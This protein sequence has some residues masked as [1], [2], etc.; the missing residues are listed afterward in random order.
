MTTDTIQSNSSIHGDSID[1]IIRP[2]VICGPSGSGK[3][4]LLRLLINDYKEYLGFTVSH[5]TRKPRE[6]EIDGREYHFTERESMEKA[7][8][9][10]EFI[11]F[12]EFSGNLYG[13]SKKAMEQVQKGGKICVLDLEIEGVKNMKKSNLKPLFVFV[14]PPSLEVLEQRLRARGTESIENIDRRLK[15]AKEDLCM[16]G[17][18]NYFDLIIINEDLDEAYAALKNF[19]Q[20]AIEIVKSARL[21]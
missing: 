9:D 16:E 5:T 18:E 20:P 8:K 17:I 11:E 4:T 10:G 14:K 21:N 1:P 12:T 19:I 2:I 7:I 13:T 15:R 3:S 6:G